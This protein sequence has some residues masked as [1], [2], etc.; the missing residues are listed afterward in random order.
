MSERTEI[1]VIKA[2][3]PFKLAKIVSKRKRPVF[4]TNE[5]NNI[6]CRVIPDF[7]SNLDIMIEK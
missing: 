3:I 7:F 2:S 4:K 6:L 5:R 1:S